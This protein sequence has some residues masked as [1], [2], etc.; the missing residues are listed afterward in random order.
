MGLNSN[1]RM[2]LRSLCLQKHKRPSAKNSEKPEFGENMVQHMA[3]SNKRIENRDNSHSPTGY[4]GPQVSSGNREMLSQI[5]NE[6]S[7]LDRRQRMF[8]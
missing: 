1:M 3:N 2:I 6:N 4:L 8:I 5:P 7:R